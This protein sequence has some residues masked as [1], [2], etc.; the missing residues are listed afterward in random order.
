MPS[1]RTTVH[2]C[3]FIVK[4]RNCACVQTIHVYVACALHRPTLHAARVHKLFVFM[5]YA[6]AQAYS[7]C[8]TG[9]Y[10]YR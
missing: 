6:G 8:P 1:W 9:A 10:C 3:R 5:L 7:P 4:M 2:N